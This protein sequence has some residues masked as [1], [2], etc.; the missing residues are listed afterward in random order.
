MSHPAVV[1][2]EVTRTFG[3]LKALDRFSLTV[4]PGTVL[5]VVGRNGAGKT[6]MLRLADGLLFPDAG[7]ISVLGLDP[8]TQGIELRRKISLL[9]E[10][11]SLY[12]WMTVQ[13]ILDFGAALRPGWDAALSAKLVH[14]LDLDGR[15][16]IKTLSRGSKAKVALILAVA[17]RPEVLLL[18]D[19]TAGLDPLV[20][21][22]VLAGLLDVVS[23]AGGVVI[24][25]S[26]LVH[27]I[28]RVA[29]RVAFLDGGQLNFEGSLEGLKSTIC[30]AR[31]VFAGD[32][33]GSFELSGKI[34]WSTDGRVLTV[35]A[36]ATNGDLNDTLSALGALEIEVEQLP[37]EEILVA[38]L[39]RGGSK[40]GGA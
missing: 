25:A 2:T 35:V 22:E 20:R 8:V 24:Y 37:L 19:P 30:R 18:D 34:D 38:Y 26:H 29:D 17:N 7:S 13:E 39:R 12:P 10:E 40:G 23:T 21:R 11:S 14:E 5:G 4:E 27:E 33:P 15:A 31:A 36:E 3:K 28:E 32:A 6:T 1:F 16:L 9:A